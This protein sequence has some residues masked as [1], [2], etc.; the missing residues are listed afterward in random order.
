MEEQQNLRVEQSQYGDLVFIHGFPDTYE[1][2][3]FKV[4]ICKLIFM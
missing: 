2:L 1:K 3:H 4:K